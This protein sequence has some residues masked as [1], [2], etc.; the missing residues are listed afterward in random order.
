[1]VIRKDFLS[2]MFA[3]YGALYDRCSEMAKQRLSEEKLDSYKYWNDKCLWCLN[4]RQK[5][6]VKLVKDRL[7]GYE[8]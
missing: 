7:G 8:L 5:I 4:K 2:F 1:M 6:L 3:Y